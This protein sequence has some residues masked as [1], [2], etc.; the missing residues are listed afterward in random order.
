MVFAVNGKGNFLTCFTDLDYKKGTAF[1]VGSPKLRP[2]L[3]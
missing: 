3:K 1:L 2:C